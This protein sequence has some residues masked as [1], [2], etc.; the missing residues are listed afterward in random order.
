MD[1][2]NSE[3]RKDYEATINARETIRVKSLLLEFYDLCYRFIKDEIDSTPSGD[4]IELGSGAGHIKNYL[5]NCITTDILPLPDIDQKVD[6]CS[7]PFKKETLSGICM[8]NVFHHIPDVEQFLSEAES[9]LKPGGKIVMVEPANTRWA[10]WVY[11]NLH[12]EPFNPEVEEWQLPPGSPLTSANGALPW[13]VFE[14]DWE[15]ITSQK[16]PNFRKDKMKPVLP[17]MYLLSGG[18]TWPQI[19]PSFLA[20]FLDAIMPSGMFYKIVITKC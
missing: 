2:L 14:R 18:L 9:V 7:L 17:L 15:A 4:I 3:F 1:S 10:R 19:V 12:H 20:H 8:I 6:A 5:P 16:F 13:I 11:N